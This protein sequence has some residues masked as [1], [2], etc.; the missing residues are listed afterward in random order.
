MGMHW[1]NPLKF[2]KQWDPR[3]KTTNMDNTFFKALV[4]P[5]GPSVNADPVLTS[6]PELKTYVEV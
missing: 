6:D 2:E 5:G 4:M 3:N 1:G